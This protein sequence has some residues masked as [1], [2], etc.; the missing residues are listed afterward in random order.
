MLVK[1]NFVVNKIATAVGFRLLQLINNSV[2]TF[3]GNNMHGFYSSP[4]KD[5][6]RQR[7]FYAR[8]YAREEF[9]VTNEQIELLLKELNK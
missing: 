6:I 1:E 8:E 4:I 3:A 5:L 9:D 7:V 2:Y